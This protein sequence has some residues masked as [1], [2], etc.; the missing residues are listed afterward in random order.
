MMRLSQYAFHMQE[1]IIVGT[2][3]GTHRI[4]KT[5]FASNWTLLSIVLICDRK[6]LTL[7]FLPELHTRILKIHVEELKGLQFTQMHA[8][9]RPHSIP[10]CGCNGTQ[11]NGFLVCDWGHKQCT[12]WKK[13]PI[14]DEEMGI[15]GLHVHHSITLRIH[16]LSSC[17]HVGTM[18]SLVWVSGMAWFS[19][20]CSKLKWWH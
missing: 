15:R 18:G 5:A 6:W 17:Q 12:N 3:F 13:L 4:V 14:M 19:E 2:E 10:V 1:C 7:N 16:V 20:L 9:G 8:S 11:H